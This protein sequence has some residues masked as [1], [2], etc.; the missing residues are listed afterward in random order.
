MQKR[1]KKICSDSFVC[2][3]NPPLVLPASTRR[4]AATTIN[5]VLSYCFSMELFHEGINKHLASAEAKGKSK[6]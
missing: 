4:R 1:R 6:V 3:A 5:C 2:R